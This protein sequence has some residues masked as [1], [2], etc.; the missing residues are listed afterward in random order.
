MKRDRYPTQFLTTQ[1][2]QSSLAELSWAELV[3]HR[4][5]KAPK[6]EPFKT[7]LSLISGLRLTGVGR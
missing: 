3:L 4:P 7:S 2:D 1:I 6:K 5:R